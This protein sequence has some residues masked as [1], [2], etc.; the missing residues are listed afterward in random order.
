[1]AGLVVPGAGVGFFRGEVFLSSLNT[2]GYQ[3]TPLGIVQ[4][5]DFNDSIS[6]KELLAPQFRGAAAVG[7]SGAKIS[8]TC[9][10]ASMNAQV[11]S[12][13]RGSAISTTVEVAT[14]GTVVTSTTLTLVSRSGFDK[15]VPCAVK[16]F[17]VDNM[18]GPHALFYC[19][20]FGD[21]KNPQ[22]MNDFTV[23]DATF[24]CYPDPANRKFYD[25]FFPGNQTTALA[26]P[27]QYSAGDD[28]G[29]TSAASAYMA[30]TNPTAVAVE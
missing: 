26:L 20:V 6:V 15:T 1:M 24:M 28:P 13:I 14:S 27:A 19:V 8:G 22:K 11:L 25:L 3:N 7:Q 30:L 17:D 2:A 5:F 23:W 21:F 18:G 4:A 12:V 29:Y 10:F 16:L 9:K